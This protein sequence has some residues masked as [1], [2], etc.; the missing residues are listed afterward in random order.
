[1]ASLRQAALVS[2]ESLEA[3]TY[4][5]QHARGEERQECVYGRGEVGGIEGKKMTHLS[6]LYGSRGQRIH[7]ADVC[8]LCLNWGAPRWSSGR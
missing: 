6:W 8:A 7:P 3:F 2:K 5:R 1:M 4:N